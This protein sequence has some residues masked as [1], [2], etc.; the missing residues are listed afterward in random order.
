VQTTLRYFEDVQVGDRFGSD[1]YT[2]T[3][4]AIIAFAREFDVQ[5]FHLDRAAA[6]KSDFRELVASGWH[7]AAVAMR[8]FTTGELRFAGGCIGLAVDELRWPAAV[9]AGDTLKLETEILQMR[10]SRS[11]ADRGVLQIRNVASNQHGD[12]VLSFNAQ[13]LVRCRAAA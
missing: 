5:A 8:L 10:R 12:I 4:E 3:E 2:M 7:T 6:L 9:R 11:N 1:S 13:T